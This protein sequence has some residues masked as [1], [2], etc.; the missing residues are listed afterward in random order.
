MDPISMGMVGIG[1]AGSSLIGLAA[2][3]KR[4]IKI[5]TTAINILLEMT[6]YGGLLYL[7]QH[8]QKL[9]F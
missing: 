5:N 3:E 9:F 8:V 1:V 7:L 4:G 2:L 6:K